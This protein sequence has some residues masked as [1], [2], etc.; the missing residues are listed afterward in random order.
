MQPAERALLDAVGKQAEDSSTASDAG[1]ALEKPRRQQLAESEMPAL[2]IGEILSI[3]SC[4]GLFAIA[5]VFSFT[6][7]FGSWE[8][9]YLG[10]RYQVSPVEVGA[11]LG[12]LS[13]VSKLADGVMAGVESALINKGWSTLSIRKG[14]V[15]HCHGCSPAWIRL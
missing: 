4:R 2:S 6:Y 5:A 14:T 3:S 11:S 10:E 15:G 9:A 13:I 7:P 12:S 1:A 8:P